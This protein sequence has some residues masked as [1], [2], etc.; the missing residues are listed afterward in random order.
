MVEM[1]F[2]N[3]PQAKAHGQ[4]VAEVGAGVFERGQGFPLFA[5]GAADRDAHVGMA[6]IGGDMYF[7][8]IDGEEAGV[9]GFETDDFGKLLAD[10]LG[11]A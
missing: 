3:V 10:C 11:D 4:F 8:D 2:G 1:E 9:V 7:D 6:A 5:L